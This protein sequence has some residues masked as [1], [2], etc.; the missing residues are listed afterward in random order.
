V[1]VQVV[2]PAVAQVAQ[3]IEVAVE[4]PVADR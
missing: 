4:V 1:E 2:L 3:A